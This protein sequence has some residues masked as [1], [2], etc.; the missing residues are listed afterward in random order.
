[1][2]PGVRYVH[3]RYNPWILLSQAAMTSSSIDEGQGWP[4]DLKLAAMT[5][6]PMIMSNLRG[7]Y[8]L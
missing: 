7:R 5:S 2:L 6:K 4:I 8:H 3:G 1:M